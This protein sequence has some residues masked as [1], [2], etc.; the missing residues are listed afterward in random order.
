VKRGDDQGRKLGPM[1]TEDTARSKIRLAEKKGA[2]GFDP[3][4][5]VFASRPPRRKRDLKQVEEWLKAKRLAEESKREDG[6]AAE[7]SQK[8]KSR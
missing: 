8:A 6:S 7:P 1:G 2:A 3:Y 4:K 5:G